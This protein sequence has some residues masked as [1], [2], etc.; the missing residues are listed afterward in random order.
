MKIRVYLAGYIDVT[1]AINQ[2]GNAQI[3]VI[4]TPKKMEPVWPPFFYKV[5]M[6]TITILLI[7]FF[8][9]FVVF[10]IINKFKRMNEIEKILKT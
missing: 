8:S 1:N 4:D 9:V 2:H 6:S 3:F 10:S 5:Y 7:M